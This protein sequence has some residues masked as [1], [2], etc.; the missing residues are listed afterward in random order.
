[1]KKSIIFIS[2]LLCLCLCSCSADEIPVQDTPKVEL[3]LMPNDG[4]NLSRKA[5]LLEREAEKK[6]AEEQQKNPADED[7]ASDMMNL[8]QIASDELL[9][10]DFGGKDSFCSFLIKDSDLHYGNWKRAKVNLSPSEI[11]G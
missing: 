5:V 10:L 11:Q 3:T 9:A 6:A 2:F 4:I 1:M 7:A 8:L